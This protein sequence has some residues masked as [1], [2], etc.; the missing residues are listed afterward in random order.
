MYLVIDC[1]TTGLPKDRRASKQDVDNWPRVIQLAWAL[2]DESGEAGEIMTPV[3]T[4]A[5]LIRPE[6]FIIPDDVQRIHGITTERAHSEGK[7]LAEILRAFALA[8]AKAEVI[9]AH[10]LDFDVSVI[11]AEYQ[12]LGFE[13]PF[14]GKKQICTMRK[15]VEFCKIPGKRGFKWPKLS[16]LHQK[17]FGSDFEGAHDAGADVAACA[18]C[19]FALKNRNEV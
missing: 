2:Y 19:F 8:A 10:N 16:Q 11:S 18:R 17:L 14:G 9:V 1:E 15:S 12:R 7:D 5:C 13:S 3:E 6:G 4:A